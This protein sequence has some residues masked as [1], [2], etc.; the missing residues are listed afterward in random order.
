MVCVDK[1]NILRLWLELLGPYTDFGMK[2]D[3]VLEKLI[4][5]RFKISVSMKVFIEKRELGRSDADSNAESS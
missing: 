1:T 5:N 4:L 2:R 3:L